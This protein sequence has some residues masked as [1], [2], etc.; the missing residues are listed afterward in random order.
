MCVR[1]R[2][3][4]SVY[5]FVCVYVCERERKYECVSVCERE[6]EIERDDCDLF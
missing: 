6:I 1:K 5:V 3:L 2:E 4:L